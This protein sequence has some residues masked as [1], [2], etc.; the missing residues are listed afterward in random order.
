MH[1]CASRRK[2]NKITK[3]AKG[4]KAQPNAL[5]PPKLR[6]GSPVFEVMKSRPQID[7]IRGVQER[8]ERA[9][10]LSI[11]PGAQPEMLHQLVGSA[12]LVP[13]LVFHDPLRPLTEAT[14]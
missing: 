5:N 9:R 6:G 10:R 12:V 14:S 7:P 1:I 3:Q 8:L 2:D 11:V 4:N 13:Q